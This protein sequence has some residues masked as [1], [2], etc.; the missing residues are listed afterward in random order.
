MHRL[1]RGILTLGPDPLYQRPVTASSRYQR[2]SYGRMPDG[3][4]I[5]LHTL[6]NRQN[7]TVRL[8]D[9]GAIV[10]NIVVPDASGQLSD[11]VVGF[12][13][14]NGYL[15][16]TCFIGSVVGRYAN[17]IADGDLVID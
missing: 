6:T 3:R 12:D 17:R 4:E 5:H 7:A 2:Q 13:D 15:N 11:V 9:Y 14:L 8:I 1:Q 10:T 16:D